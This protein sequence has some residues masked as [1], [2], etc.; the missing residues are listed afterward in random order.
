[1]KVYT[2]MFQRGCIRIV[3]RKFSELK[4]FQKYFLE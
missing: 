4:A 3:K 1:M 2:E